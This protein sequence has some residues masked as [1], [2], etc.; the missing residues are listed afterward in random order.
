MMARTDESRSRAFF[1]NTLWSFML[2]I[3]T[4]VVGFIVPRTIIACYGSDVNGLVASLTQIVGYFSLVEA[5][6]S[7]AAVFALY[8]PL[9]EKNTSQI[10]IIVSAAKRFYYRSGWLFVALVACLAFFYP[11]VVKCDGMNHVQ[12]AVLVFSLGAMGVFDFFSLAKYRVLLTA[13]QKNWVIQGASIVYKIL[14]AAIIV[15][16]AYQNVSVEVVYTLAIGAIV[17]RSIILSIYTRRKYPFVNYASDTQGYKFPQRWDALVLQILGVVQAG[18]PIVIATFLLND[19]AM[20][21]VFSVYQLVANGV[22]NICAVVTTGTQA[23]FGDAIARGDKAAL[24]RAYGE[25]CSLVG[26]LSS[27]ACVVA[28]VLIDPFMVLYTS[29]ISEINYVYP[30]LGFLLIVNVFLYHL[31]TPQGLMVVSAGKYRESRPY[32]IMQTVVLL[33]GAT[34]GGAYFGLNGIAAGACLSNIYAAVYL[35]FFVPTKITG[36]RKRDT[37]SKM[38][39]AVICFVALGMFISQIPF[40]ASNWGQ[41]AISLVMLGCLCLGGS[42]LFYL[43]VDRRDTLALLARFKRVLSPFS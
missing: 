37:L 32:V 11:I 2:Q 1:N 26:I 10:S 16:L 13:S 33:V 28:L 42:F 31:K 24:K 6:I 17:V 15:T 7:A 39:R 12:V 29:G 3:V 8:A 34:V 43:L 30:T 5:G 9:A 25:M 38:A 19:L 23:S 14:Y 40:E 41:W 20:V 22:Q 36:T 4:L 21:S 18:A 35:I 27:A